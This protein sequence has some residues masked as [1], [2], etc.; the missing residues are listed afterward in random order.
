VPAVIDMG[1][2]ELIMEQSGTCL[3]E[4][5]DN[6]RDMPPEL[7]FPPGRKLECLH[8]KHRIQAA[9]ELRFLKAE[10]K[11]WVVDLYL[12][13][14]LYIYFIQM[15]TM[16]LKELSQEARRSLVEEYSNSLNFS[17]GETYRKI[18]DISQT[19]SL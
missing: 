6:P 19:I 1:D 13:K 12:G 8:G 16:S 9:K 2:L 18:C 11:W 17:D 3:A 10:D 15:L 4:L 5:L 7:N 14:T